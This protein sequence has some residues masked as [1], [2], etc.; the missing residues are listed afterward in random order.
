MKSVD[1]EQP[2][3]RAFSLLVQA[4]DRSSTPFSDRVTVYINIADAND[5]APIPTPGQSGRVDENS[6]IGTR[7]TTLIATDADQPMTNN[8]KLSFYLRNSISG[9]FA[10]N[11]VTGRLTVGHNNSLDY[12]IVTIYNITWYVCDAGIPMLCS[13]DAQLSIQLNNLN[14]NN[15]TITS[16][17]HSITVNESTPVGTLL[18]AILADDADAPGATLRFEISPADP[19]FIIHSVQGI[20]YLASNLDYETQQLHVITII[21]SDMGT[22]I[23]S[24]SVNFTVYVT[25]RNDNMPIFGKVSYIFYI[26]EN[27]PDDTLVGNVTATDADSDEHGIIQF[28][29]NEDT[30]MTGVFRIVQLTNTLAQIRVVDGSK[31]DREVK[32]DYELIVNATDNVEG[33]SGFG[34]TGRDSK[35]THEHVQV[36]KVI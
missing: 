26:Y 25:D 18:G 9:L 19:L 29:L 11:S 31:L 23:L 17:V 3:Q 27:S 2:G 33:N 30:S 20:I 10:V 35:I 34:D 7:V 8:T 15:P 28:T 16:T 14:D 4:E 5:N 32:K 24:S 21:I 36:S 13:N 22:P 12:E 6:I 1:Y